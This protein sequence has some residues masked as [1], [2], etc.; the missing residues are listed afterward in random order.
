[1][2]RLYGGMEPYEEPDDLDPRALVREVP[3]GWSQGNPEPEG[4]SVDE[5]DDEAPTRPARDY[6]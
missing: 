2:T 1:M 3:R 5:H 6:S 4:E